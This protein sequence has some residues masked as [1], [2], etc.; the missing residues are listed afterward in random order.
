VVPQ[1]TKAEARVIFQS[2]FKRKGPEEVKDDEFNYFFNKIPKFEKDKEPVTF[3]E[4]KKRFKEYAEEI[5]FT[6]TK[7]ETEKDTLTKAQT[8]FKTT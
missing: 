3:D 2:V 7:A 4:L 8:L 5:H 1:A 6:P